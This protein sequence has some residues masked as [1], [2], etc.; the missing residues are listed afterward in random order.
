MP[1]VV[2]GAPRLGLGLRQRS[3]GVCLRPRVHSSTRAGAG[4]LL[5]GTGA[6]PGAGDGGNV[7]C[8]WASSTPSEFLDCLSLWAAASGRGVE[9]PD[10]DTGMRG[11]GVLRGDDEAALHRIRSSHSDMLTIARHPQPQ[12]HPRHAG[13]QLHQLT[14]NGSRAADHATPER[15]FVA[16]EG[17]TGYPWRAGPRLVITEDQR[18]QRTHA[19]CGC[20]TVVT[21]GQTNGIFQRRPPGRVHRRFKLQGQLPENADRWRKISR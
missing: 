5:A 13:V 7:L 6:Q 12:R 4:R 2:R 10:P 17:Q 14:S 9:G 19:S 20:A 15:R 11:A 18:D 16:G 21:Q 3:G 8:V 1:E